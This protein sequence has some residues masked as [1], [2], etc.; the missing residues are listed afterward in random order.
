MALQQAVGATIGFVA[1]LPTSHDDTGFGTL[2]YETVG[3]LEGYPDLDGVYDIATFTGLDSGEEE[4]FVDVLR[5]G[6]SS[7]MVGLDPD[8]AG[9]TAVETAFRDGTKGSFEFTLKDGTVYYRTAA[10]TSYNPTNIGVGNVVMADLG[11]E[12]EKTTIKVAAP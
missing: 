9:Q 6:N 12:F 10:I 5:A 1:E 3:K 2:T 11:L 4:K 7:F 8:D